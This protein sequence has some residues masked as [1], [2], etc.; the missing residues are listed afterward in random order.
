MINR[1]KTNQGEQGTQSR[2][3]GPIY[4]L[5][6][7]KGT[8]IRGQRQ[9]DRDKETETRRQRQ[10]DR[11]KETETRRQTQGDIVKETETRRQR[12]GDRDKRWVY[13]VCKDCTMYI[14]VLYNIYVHM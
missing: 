10:G 12:Q 1:L 6:V 14:C 11:Y 5:G 7:D 3:S 4:T 9:G 2:R 13:Y 8:K